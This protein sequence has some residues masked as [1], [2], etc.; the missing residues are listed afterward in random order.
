MLGIGINVTLRTI[1]LPEELR[2]TATSLAEESAGSAPRSL[3]VEVALAAT[4]TALER[5]L[6]ASP[7]AI[8]AAW[9]ARDAL[10]GR[11]VSWDSGEGVA[12][13]IDPSGALV[14]AL[15]DGSRTELHA[16]EVMLV[17]RGEPDGP[18]SG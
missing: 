12:A 8:G 17:R 1:D 5:W 14:V 2:E 7:E 3:T 18:G 15:P 9:N 6:T 13:G 4:T 10:L 11:P 16:G